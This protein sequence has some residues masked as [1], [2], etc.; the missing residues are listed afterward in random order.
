MINQHQCHCHLDP[1]ALRYWL[2]WESNKSRSS[3]YEHFDSGDKILLSTAMAIMGR[4]Y[5][6]HFQRTWSI[7]VTMCVCVRRAR[8]GNQQSTTTTVILSPFL[9]A[10]DGDDDDGADG[11]DV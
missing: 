3:K 1:A 11:Y 6:V 5:S 8:R 4:L 2:Q 7:F 9:M 10:W